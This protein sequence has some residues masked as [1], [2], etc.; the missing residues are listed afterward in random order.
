MIISEHVD[1]GVNRKQ[2][3]FFFFSIYFTLD[4]VP[5]KLQHLFIV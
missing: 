1:K 2:E 5:G 3:F 4:A